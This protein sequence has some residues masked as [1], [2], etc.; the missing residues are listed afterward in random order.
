MRPFRPAAL[1]VVSFLAVSACAST[2]T[3]PQSEASKSPAVVATKPTAPKALIVPKVSA[4]EL[5]RVTYP[6][7]K[8]E[9]TRHIP[10]QKSYHVVAAC[11]SSDPKA[12][13]TWELRDLRIIDD[14]EDGVLASRPV[15]CNGV[16]DLV[17]DTRPLVG[18]K[19][20]LVLTKKS[21]GITR[22][23]TVLRSGLQP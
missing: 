20:Q 19:L 13:L 5:A 3:P 9:T 21:K 8:T 18:G 14:L 4:R 15:L 1:T 10:G 12:T 6:G 2:S 22:A 17:E 11:S 23:Y 16:E 7:A